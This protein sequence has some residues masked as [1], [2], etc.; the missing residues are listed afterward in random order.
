M[1]VDW[2][3]SKLTIGLHITKRLIHLVIHK[4]LILVV[5]DILLYLL[6][7]I[8]IEHRRHWH[9]LISTGVLLDGVFTACKLC[10]ISIRFVSRTD[11]GLA[12]LIVH[13]IAIVFHVFA[14]VNRGLC[15][16]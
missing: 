11:L 1:E 9:Q 4:V 8:A 15:S 13:R 7:L 6:I 5:D 12:Y 3:S 16:A 14:R 10:Q 2:L